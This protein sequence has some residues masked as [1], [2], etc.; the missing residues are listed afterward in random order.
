MKQ[1]K[2]S[3]TFA[4]RIGESLWIKLDA[5]PRVKR[6]AVIEQIRDLLESAVSE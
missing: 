4:V 5:L 3:K 1:E 2:L 6:R